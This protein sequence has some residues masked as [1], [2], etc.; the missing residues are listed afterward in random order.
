MEKALLVYP[1]F[2]PYGFWNYKDVCRLVGA[3]YPA[4]PLGMITLAALL[5]QEW[6]IRL[7]DM[8]TSV[9]RDSDIDWADL[10][11]IGGMLPQQVNTL[12]LINRIIANN[13]LD[14]FIKFILFLTS[15]KYP[16]PIQ[17]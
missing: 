12:K 1:E 8:N 10:V 16:Y 11:F 17:I 14:F 4:A 2:S 15:L 5:P 6:N 3:K 7:V 9:L 13:K